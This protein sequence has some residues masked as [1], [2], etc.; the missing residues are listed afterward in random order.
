MSGIL[1]I[2]LTFF[3][4]ILKFAATRT[5]CVLL[6]SSHVNISYQFLYLLC[7]K[8]HSAKSKGLSCSNEIKYLKYII[9]VAFPKHLEKVLQTAH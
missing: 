9:S 8:V 2:Y 1:S 7:E 4:V 3:P 5:E 6:L